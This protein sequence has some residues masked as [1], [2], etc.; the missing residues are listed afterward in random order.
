MRI[1]DYLWIWLDARMPLESN[2][3]C[4]ETLIIFVNRV[5]K[6]VKQHTVTGA[7]KCIHEYAA[8]TIVTNLVKQTI[9]DFCDQKLCA[10]NHP[11]SIGLTVTLV[12]L[13]FH[14]IFCSYI[15]RKQQQPN[16]HKTVLDAQQI[17]GH[18]LAGW[19]TNL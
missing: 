6:V 17:M 18:N 9:L 10:Q 5:C 12:C 1:L 2:F 15:V 11:L 8:D 14:H 19:I 3:F 16:H 7:I 4:A 13:K